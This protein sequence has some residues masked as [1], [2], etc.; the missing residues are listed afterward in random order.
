MK[1]LFSHPA[2]NQN[3]RAMLDGLEAAG[4]LARF[5]TTLAVAPDNPALKLVP[6]G[7]SRD[8]LRR[9]FNIP[10]EK[11]LQHP[12]RELTRAICSRVGW[13]YWLRH[14]TGF[15]SI[16]GVLQDFDRFTARALQRLHRPC[17]L[18]AVYTYEDSALDTFKAARPLGV[19]CVYDLPISYW[20]VGRKLMEEEVER[21]PAWRQALGGGMSDS[22]AKLERKAQ[23]LELADLVV[24]ASRF[25]AES[26]PSWAANKARVLSP[27][28]S[29]VSATPPPP[30]V[31][32][33]S[34]PLRVLF[35]GSMG[36]RKGLGDLFQAMH[37]LKGENIEL[38]VMGS[39]LA[40]LDFYRGQYAGFTH[41]K[42]RPHAE[43]LALMRSCDVFCL[44]SLYEGR[45]LVM[46]EAMSQ[47]LPIVITPNT[48]GDDLVIE[49]KTGFLVPIRSPEKIAEKLAWFNQNRQALPA[50][51]EAA[52]QHA[53]GYTWKG[54][55][56]VVIDAIRKLG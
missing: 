5:T 49:G 38:V 53:A 37:L 45:A 9:R 14:E 54:Y 35:V 15:A 27:F 33:P 20:E 4:M 1:V 51:S 8:L 2:G 36:Q 56:E 32:D 24:V 26:L 28:G 18:G 48:G 21:L 29:P 25:V 22:P 12:L 23:E 7:L 50:M 11:I 31:V 40:D 34:K 19:K 42:G 46:Q 43:V 16:D 52:V 3:V 47:G 17:D 44:P 6:Q 39:P 55:S 13:D 41:E 30:K 10:R